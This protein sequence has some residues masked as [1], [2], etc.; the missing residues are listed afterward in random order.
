MRIYA[1]VF[2]AFVCSSP[3]LVMATDDRDQPLPLTPDVQEKCLT[4]LRAG[5]ASDEFWPAMHAAE[6]LTLAGQG[7]EVR[8]AL[9]P[10]LPTE[11]D[12]QRRCGLVRELVRT[13]DRTSLPIMWQILADEKSNGRIHA[14]ESL[15]KVNELDDGRLMRSVFASAEIPKLKLMAA[16]ALAR[17]GDQDAYKLLR[18]KLFDDDFETRKVAAWVLGLLGDEQDIA[19]LRK[20]L[21][22]E[23]DRLAK[24]YYVNALA[25]LRD[26]AG[27]QALIKNLSSKEGPIRTYSADFAGYARAIEAQP[28]LIEMLTDENLDVRIRSAQSLIAL[29]LPPSALKL[30]IAAVG[31]AASVAEKPARK[32]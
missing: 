23:T 4:V 5:L 30:P 10:K 27:R 1:F 22:S 20:V 11:K 16:A 3:N 24:A 9:R 13:G 14:A 31:G 19:P 29:S 18:E 21:A 12:D 7:E 6:A 28:R 17:G 8:I 2:L 15:Y 32:E 26:A 25:C